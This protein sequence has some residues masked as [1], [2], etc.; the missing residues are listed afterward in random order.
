MKMGVILMK[1]LDKSFNA[2]LISGACSILV[3]CGGG[4]D[5]PSAPLVSTGVFIDSPVSGI[6]YK[7]A[8]QSGVTNDKGE[9]K[10]ISGQ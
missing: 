10:Y 5:A 7:T 8:S 3:A 2:L 6:S 9:F 1:F 4:S